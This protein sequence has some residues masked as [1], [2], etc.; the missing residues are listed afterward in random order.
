VGYIDV[1]KSQV[2]PRGTSE[3]S[4]LFLRYKQVSGP[5]NVK[6]LTIKQPSNKLDTPANLTTPTNPTRP[7]GGA[8]G[9][10]GPGAG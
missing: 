7:T 1:P 5:F 8:S 6:I 4:K 3:F 10:G 9:G 2:E